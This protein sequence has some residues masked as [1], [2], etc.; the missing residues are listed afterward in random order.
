MI[1]VAMEPKQ[2]PEYVQAVVDSGGQV[3]PLN[4]DVEAL[5]WLDYSNPTGLERMLDENPQIKWVQLPFAGVDAFSEIIKRPI[6][7]TSAK[8]AYREPVA[9][10]ALALSLAMMRVIPE[11]VKAK[12][13]G[14]QFA[15]SLYDSNV[16]IIG[17]GG[18]TE[19]LIKLLSPFRAKVTVLRNQQVPMPNATKTMQLHDLDLALGQAD[20]VIVACALTEQTQGLF[21]ATKFSKMKKSAYLVNIARGPVIN[22]QDL[23]QAL[24]NDVIAGAAVDV[25][26]PEPL[27]EGH[28]LWNA[29]NMIITPHTA[30]TRA[31]VVRLFS[32]RIRENIRA[33]AKGSGWVGEVDPSRGY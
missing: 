28:P 13:W 17:A 11:R 8:G 25:T 2:F 33:Y 29:K 3:V 7:F 32:E 12:S 30:D 27:P 20:L 18:I 21:N 15:D 10:H 5:I 1:S 9:E 16:L 19:E 31:Q 14:R 24:N 23:V 4:Q 22:T 6:R 26:D